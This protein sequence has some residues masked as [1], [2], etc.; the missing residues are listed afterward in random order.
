MKFLD[1]IMWILFI[2]TIIF[3]FWYIF[4]NS[5]TFEQAILV[6]V[7]T[8]VFSLVIKITRFETR[9]DYLEKNIKDS[10]TNLKEDTSLIKHKIKI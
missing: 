10:F 1:I 9:L 8:A 5:P 3:I 4:G 6:F 7:V 2:I